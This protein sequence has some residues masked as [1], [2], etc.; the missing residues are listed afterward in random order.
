MEGWWYTKSCETLN[1]NLQ[2]TVSSISLQ[3]S[4]AYA[5]EAVQNNEEYIIGGV[6]KSTTEKISGTPTMNDNYE[7]FE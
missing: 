1:D 7:T 5:M 4:R 3:Q 2:W 6:G